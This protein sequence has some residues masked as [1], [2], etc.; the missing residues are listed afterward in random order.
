MFNV[1]SA[2]ARAH[3]QSEIL[4]VDK[5]RYRSQDPYLPTPPDD[6]MSNQ[7]PPETSHHYAT[8]IPSRDIYHPSGNLTGENARPSA[9]DNYGT[10]EAVPPIAPHHMPYYD[11]RG[12]QDVYH[13]VGRDSRVA[14]SSRGN[15][16]PYGSHMRGRETTTVIDTHNLPSHRRYS[17]E[18]HSAILGPP[19]TYSNE[20]ES[21]PSNS[22]QDG[23]NEP[24]KPKKPRR[25]KPRI[26]LA[27]D[28]PPT[29][30]GKPR[31]RV[32]VAC[33]QWCV[34]NSYL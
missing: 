31:A 26:E 17:P 33:L 6:Y 18:P 24:S 13:D 28:Q 3:S 20:D 15:V 22:P 16:Q 10:R 2:R 32:Y 29:T 12:P 9:A 23:S 27:P 5:P 19:S 14:E 1:S 7:L 34:P 4:N 30:Q 11:R 8:S 25:E 21:W